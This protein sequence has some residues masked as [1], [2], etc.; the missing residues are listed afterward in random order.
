MLDQ[1]KIG[2]MVAGFIALYPAWLMYQKAFM[3]TRKKLGIAVLS[4]LLPFAILAGCIFIPFLLHA[5]S[6][7]EELDLFIDF[8]LFSIVPAAVL[9]LI[10]FVWDQVNERP[11]RT[12]LGAAGCIAVALLPVVYYLHGHDLAHRFEITVTQDQSD[13]E[14]ISEPESNEQPAS[15]EID[16]SKNSE[17]PSVNSEPQTQSDSA[18]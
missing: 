11:S 12:V 9:G 7:I 2:A 4:F 1:V 13:S 16:E 17:L 8:V 3:M 15:E 10:G 18:N 14:E 6:E 5:N